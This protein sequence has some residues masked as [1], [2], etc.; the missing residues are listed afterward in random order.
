[1]GK[2]S[3]SEENGNR[4]KEHVTIRL[5]L[6]II[7]PL[8]KLAEDENISFTSLL[9]RILADH[10]NWHS[11]CSKAGDMYFLKPIM[12][13]IVNKLDTLELKEISIKTARAIQDKVVMLSGLFTVESFFNSLALWARISGFTF[14]HEIVGNQE[15][16]IVNFDMGG[17]F[18]YLKSEVFREIFKLLKKEA[19]IT[20]TENTVS[21]KIRSP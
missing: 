21:I 15:L 17:N 10:V 20:V 16:F 8:E 3:K 7:K 5:P 12:Q 6:T 13:D 4:P 2:Y 14:K 18:T 19:E 11:N 9:T 1:M